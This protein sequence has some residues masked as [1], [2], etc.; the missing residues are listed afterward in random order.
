MSSLIKIR[1]LHK[2]FGSTRALRGVDLEIPT[3]EIVVL[4]GPSGCGKSTI[5]RTWEGMLG[6]ENVSHTPLDA[7]GSEFR[8]DDMRGKLAN[9]ASDMKRMDKCEEGRLKELTSGEPIQV[10]RRTNGTYKKNHLLLPV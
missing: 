1:N 6:A 2:S 3:G 4:L 10:N 5:L 7:L 9:I 8:L